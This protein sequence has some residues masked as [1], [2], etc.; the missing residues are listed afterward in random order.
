MEVN[1]M[2][3]QNEL[4]IKAKKAR[5]KELLKQPTGPSAA[6]VATGLSPKAEPRIRQVPLLTALEALVGLL[7]VR[8]GPGFEETPGQVQCPGPASS[9]ALAGANLPPVGLA[10]AV[11]QHWSTQL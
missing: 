8:T 6:P 11:V 9:T 10:T 7:C 5:E 4:E 3:A 1:L 2:N